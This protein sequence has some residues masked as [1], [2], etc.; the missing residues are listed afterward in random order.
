MSGLASSHC[1]TASTV[2]DALALAAAW[3][4]RAARPRSPAPW[5]V[6]ATPWEVRGPFATYRAGPLGAGVGV[7]G[8]AG[9]TA[10]GSAGARGMRLPAWVAAW[11]TDPQAA[12]TTEIAPS[13][14]RRREIISP[15]ILEAVD[16]SSSDARRKPARSGP[17]P[18]GVA[19]GDAGS[20]RRLLRSLVAPVTPRWPSHGQP[21]QPRPG[22]ERSHPRRPAQPRHGP[23]AGPGRSFG[24]ARAP[25]DRGPRQ[26]P[27]HRGRPAGEHRLAVPSPRLPRPDGLRPTR[28]CLLLPRR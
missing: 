7:G 14:A 27:G 6:R 16:E 5:K 15:S 3:R 9:G 17:A 24:A 1:P 22:R 11:V 25:P 8:G 18:H 4:R 12:S 28:R 13:R 10:W 26:L 20:G 21:R 19:L 23:D 2:I